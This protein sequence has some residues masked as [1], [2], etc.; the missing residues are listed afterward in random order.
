[1]HTILI[2][3]LVRI[4]STYSNTVQF[5]CRESLDRHSQRFW[6]IHK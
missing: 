3:C 4:S 6:W 5:V 1:M 2:Y